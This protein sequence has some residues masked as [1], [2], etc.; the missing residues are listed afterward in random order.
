MTRIKALAAT[1]SVLALGACAVAPPQGPSVIAMPGQGKTFQAFQQDDAYCRQAASASVGGVD[2][3]QAAT[4]SAVGSA[5][6][7][8]VLGAAAGALIGAA[9]GN[10]GA[11]A[12]I[13]AGAGLIGGSSVGAAN[14]QVSGSQVQFRYDNTYAQCMFSQ[15]NTVSQPQPQPSFV[16]GPGPY[17]GPYWG[18]PAVVAVAPPIVVGGWGG[19]WGW[20]GG[21]GYRGWYGGR[22]WR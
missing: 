6:V 1:C 3:N 10:P 21:Y 7:G 17:V 4:Q 22:Y 20:G 15:G 14:A 19:G 8:T 2:A 9:A 13:G 11:G 5:A 12:A 16:A 18:A